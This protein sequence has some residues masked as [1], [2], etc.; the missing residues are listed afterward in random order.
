MAERILVA[1]GWPYANSETHI[2]HIAGANLPADI[3]ARY[4]RMIGNEVLKV[5]GSDTHGTPITIY[6]DQH[7]ITPAEVVE[8]FHPRFIEAYL[9]LGITFDLYTHTDTHNHWN[10]THDLFLRHFEKKYIY[11]DVQEQLYD[12]KADQ[13]LADRYVEGTCPKCG[14]K[15]AR[16]DQC[17]ACQSTYEAVELINPRSR[18]TG[19]ENLEVRSTEHFFFDLAKL[20]DPLLEWVLQDKEYWRPNVMN[21]T[22]AQLQEKKLRGRPIT[23]DIAWG[24]TI[25][26]EGYE[27]K[28]IYVWY[29]A[30][31]GYL[32]AS[33]EWSQ[34]TSQ[35][36]AW[37][38]WW[39]VSV[40]P[41]ART[42]YFIGKDNIPF[43]TIIWPGM[44]YA[45]GGL[46]LPYDV[47]SNEYLNYRGSKFSKS[48]GNSIQMNEVLDRYQADAWR[49]VLTAIAPEGNDSDFSWK[50]LL[51]R[52]NNEL[53]ANWGNLAN[54]L[55][56][57]CYK[58]FET[59]IPVPGE[60]N[61]ADKALLAEIREGFE[62]IGR[63][64]NEVRLKA[65][66]NEARRLSQRVNQYLTERAPWKLIKTDRA[67]A[68]TA[69]YTG[70][71]AIDW[72]K[73]LWSPILPHTSQQ[74]HEMFGYSGQLF[75]RQFTE[76]VVDDRGEH[77]VLR[78]DHSPAQAKWHPEHLPAG[79]QLREITPLIRKLE[80]DPAG[81]EEE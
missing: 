14:A 52:V 81:A 11:K 59:K 1:V 67:E 25:P 65:A 28:R 61:D 20:N 27:G 2:G 45:Y 10:V 69:T 36:D 16:G 62:G 31:I 13:F 32:S 56:S 80:P 18:I 63:L 26:L 76:T 77:L 8:R 41:D 37:R 47:P 51:N 12:P 21:F 70:L 40:N 60:L 58:N 64:Y 75:G 5:S 23:R 39:D 48:R 19:N 49:Y 43:H 44:L 29:D 73:I 71:Q 57:F 17:D 22:R 7:N 55:L 53:L 30:V 38:H 78:Y 66:L 3:F 46:N 72:L 4:Q 35:P 50:D 42:Y 33:K 9:R 34:L 74:L 15:D 68:A 79:Q 54:R 6:A 24:I